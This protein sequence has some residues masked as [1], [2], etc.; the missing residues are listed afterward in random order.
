MP[1]TNLD[2]LTKNI[3]TLS[4]WEIYE[5][6]TSLYT[7]N[8]NTELSLKRKTKEVLEENNFKFKK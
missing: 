6:M 4:Y 2:N 3:G 5:I 7:R 1:N 8:R